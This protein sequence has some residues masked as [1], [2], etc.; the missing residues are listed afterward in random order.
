MMLPD[1]SSTLMSWEQSVSIKN[2]SRVTVDFVSADVV[3]A[4]SLLAVVQI[5]QKSALNSV[6]IDWSLQYLMVHSRSDMLMGEYIE[7]N[8][9]DYKII[10][11]GA[12]DDYGYLEVVAEQT[13]LTLL[14][15]S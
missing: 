8:G 2:V 13:R 6:T 12:W 14:V 5:A 3:T 11:R 9:E 1:M 7:Y 15:G 10:Q 4:R